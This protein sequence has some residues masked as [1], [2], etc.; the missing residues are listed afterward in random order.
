M[1]KW[2]EPKRKHAIAENL[3]PYRIMGKKKLCINLLH[4]IIYN[5]A[6]GQPESKEHSMSQIIYYNIVKLTIQNLH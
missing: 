3:K 4:L 5:N 1:E 6:F 2:R